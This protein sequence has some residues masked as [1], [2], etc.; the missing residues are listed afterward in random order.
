MPRDC[1]GGEGVHARPALLLRASAQKYGWWSVMW[2]LDQIGGV[3]LL[4]QTV[5]EHQQ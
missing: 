5:A 2:H 3:Y 4:K 1:G